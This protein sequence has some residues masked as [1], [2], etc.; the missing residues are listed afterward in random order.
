MLRLL[1]RTVF[2]FFVFV[3]TWKLLVVLGWSISPGIVLGF[4]AGLLLLMF[5]KDIHVISEGRDYDLDRMWVKRSEMF[6]R[7]ES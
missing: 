5:F 1:I 3:V 2:Y 7:E 4:I 6:D